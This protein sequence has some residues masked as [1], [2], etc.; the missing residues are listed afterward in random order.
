[1]KS[2]CRA[3]AATAIVALASPAIA[4]AVVESQAAA[5]GDFAVGGGQY[6]SNAVT[7]HNNVKFAFS[8]QSGPTGEDPRGHVTIQSSPSACLDV[9]PGFCPPFDL[10]ISADVTCL[11]VQGSAAAIAGRVTNSDIPGVQG[12]AFEVVDNEDPLPDTI[13]GVFLGPEPIVECPF[14]GGSVFTVENGNIT[15]RDR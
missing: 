15:V 2:L 14:V 8:A 9:S 13:S 5:P 1:M 4:G 10:E 12:M 7:G 3:F 6:F 11:R